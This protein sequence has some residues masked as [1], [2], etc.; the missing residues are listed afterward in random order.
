M[1][2]LGMDV[3]IVELGDRE[4]VWLAQSRGHKVG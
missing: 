4:K 3:E 1:V 2:D